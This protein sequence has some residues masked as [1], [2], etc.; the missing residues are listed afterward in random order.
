MKIDE[1]VA[2]FLLDLEVKGRTKATMI[3]Y[4]HRLGILVR[5]LD[6]QCHI[7][8]LEQVKVVHLR[9]CVQHLLTAKHPYQ[10][11]GR[12]C[13]GDAM[14]PTTVRAFVRIFKSFFNW[15]YQEELID[16]NPTARLSPPKVP[17]RVTPAFRQ[18]H[19][20]KML[21]AC[22]TSTPIGF[23]DYVI[24]L[25]LLDTGMRV[26]ELVGLKVSDVNDRFVKVFG[27]GRRER[28]IGIH[29]EVSKLLWKYIH[30][31]RRPTEPDEETLFLGSGGKPLHL[32][33]IQEIIKR[34]QHR[35]GLDDIKFSPHV[36]RHTFAKM[37]LQRGG[38][39]FKLSREMGHSGV[40]I[41][42]EYLKD[43]NSTEARKDHTLFS[44]ISDLP[45]KK[46]HRG[47]KRQE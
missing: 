29:P 24:V 10:N 35:S 25:L 8:E 16:N 6:E 12:R 47:R 3:D 39:L 32:I 26:G 44:P 19:I 18:E 41:T 9:Q 14:A 15:C 34:I 1:A 30:K 45:L 46:Q 36:F 23:R 11:R 31:Y 28:E 33:G 17:V 43:F 42:K 22:D 2:Q 37:Y 40:E 5:L 7:T 13:E 38:D 21:D 20:E 4:R 27:K